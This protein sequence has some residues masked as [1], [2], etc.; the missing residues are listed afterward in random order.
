MSSIEKQLS[1]KVELYVKFLKYFKIFLLHSKANLRRPVA[2]A[3][4][5]AQLVANFL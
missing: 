3:L 2:T 4:A 1:L 5:Q